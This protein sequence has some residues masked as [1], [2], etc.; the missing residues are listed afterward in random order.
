MISKFYE[1][2]QN[3]LE[4][5]E[6]KRVKVTYL[7][8]FEGFVLEE[9]ERGAVVYIVSA[10]QDPD[11]ENTMMNVEPDQYQE[12]PAEE[13]SG[14]DVVKQNALQY[15]AQK[16]LVTCEQDQAVSDLMNCPCV[17]SVEHVLRGNGL[18]DSE[19]LDILKTGL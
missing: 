12:I 15:L 17:N 1:K 18:V 10:P 14:L 3:S 13:I 7:N 2:Y 6:L 5:A 11:Y 16:G 19:I 9:N 8:G 4:T